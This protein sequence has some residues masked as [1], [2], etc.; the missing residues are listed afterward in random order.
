MTPW[1]RLG[2]GHPE[3]DRQAFGQRAC[4]ATVQQICYIVGGNHVAPAARR[5]E[6]HHSVAGGNV[7]HLPAG[8]K[9][10]RLAQLFADDLQSRAHNGVVARRPGGVLPSLYGGQVGCRYGCFRVVWLGTGKGR[11]VH[12]HL[13]SNFQHDWRVS[14]AN[15]RERLCPGLDLFLR[16]A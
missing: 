13:L 9:V 10:E 6:T 4:T 16:R 1:Q 2:V 7:E 11:D 3:F 12:R 8:A 15:S 14:T 5:G